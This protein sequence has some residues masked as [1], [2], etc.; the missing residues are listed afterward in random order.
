[1]GPELLRFVAIVAVLTAVPSSAGGSGAPAYRLISCY[2]AVLDPAAQFFVRDMEGDGNDELVVADPRLGSVLIRRWG[3]DPRDPTRL[4]LYENQDI[5]INLTPPGVL[6]PVMGDVTGEGRVDLF[7]TSR[8]TERLASGDSTT[9]LS[10]TCYAPINPLC[11][12]G[13]FLR[14]CS[15]RVENSV[16]QVSLLATTDLNGDGRADILLFN[17]PFA[18]GC[19]NRSL[20]AYDA[21]TGSELWR[22]DTPTPPGDLLVLEPNPPGRL[23]PSLILGAHACGNGFR[24]G[25]WCD[26]ESFVTGVSRDGSL[27]WRTRLGGKGTGTRLMLAD[28]DGDCLPEPYVTLQGQRDDAGVEPPPRVFG[29]DPAAGSLTPFNVPD[30]THGLVA[31]DLDGRRGDEILLIGRDQILYALVRDFEVAWT[32]RDDRVRTVIACRDLDGD[33]RPEILCD[34]GDILRILDARGR[35]L[36]QTGLNGVAPLTRAACATIGRNNYLVVRQGDQIKYLRLERLPGSVAAWIWI[37][38]TSLVFTAGLV[39]ARAMRTAACREFDDALYELRHGGGGAPFVTIVRL[40]QLLAS[41]RVVNERGGAQA[42]PMPGLVADFESRVVPAI[43]RMARLGP[44]T[45]LPRALWGALDE[46]AQ[47]TRELL[48]HIVE[49]PAPDE[50]EPVARAA[51]ALHALHDRLSRLESRFPPPSKPKEVAER[52]LDR[53]RQDMQRAGVAAEVIEKGATPSRVDLAAHELDQILDN[54]VENALRALAGRAG[55]RLSIVIDVVDRR[56]IVEVSDN[57][58]GLALP[59]EKWATI[60]ARGVST[61]SAAPGE[62]P[63]GFGLYRARQVLRRYGGSIEVASSAPGAGTT[64]RITMRAARRRRNSRASAEQGSAPK[65]ATAPGG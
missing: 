6:S 48:D 39:S 4:H 28:R 16:G 37:L 19:D 13:P 62:P 51:K 64:M 45:G 53:R 52:V 8:V 12:L 20:R 43:G 65:A 2:N 47:V 63:G 46:D 26:S 42:S 22:F 44:R 11:T 34:C 7:V 36:A 60:F 3:V 14:G 32:F 9:A 30:Y 17:Y 35:E 49:R 50:P 23:Q 29:L 58:A 5:Q 1:M 40:N 59:S 24:L 10:V 55:P 33:G 15:Q 61:R 27:L 56:C 57:G 31:V 18:T 54:C 38:G 41:W 21:R 25:D